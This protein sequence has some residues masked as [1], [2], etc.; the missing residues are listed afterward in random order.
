MH[1][2]LSSKFD[3]LARYDLLHSTVLRKQ[4]IELFLE[5]ILLNLFV[6]VLD[7]DCLVG[8]QLHF[9]QTVGVRCST[10]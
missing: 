3:A 6:N 4:H 5:H 1:P 8:F 10:Q 2:Y 9:L 7:I